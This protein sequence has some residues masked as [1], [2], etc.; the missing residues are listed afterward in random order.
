MTRLD[1]ATITTQGQV[2]IPKKVR[3]KLHLQ[4]GDRIVFLEDKVGRIII[5]EAETPIEFTSDEWEEFLAKTK[6]ERVTRV[7]GKKAALSHIKRLMSH[8]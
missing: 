3:E 5:E 6:K 8:K 4:K 2:S 7:K 1:E